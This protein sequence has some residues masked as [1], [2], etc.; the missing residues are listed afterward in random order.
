MEEECIDKPDIQSVL[1]Y[2]C[3]CSGSAGG[4]HFYCLMNWIKHKIVSK[5]NNNTT[6]YQWKK[7]ECEVCKVPLP[8][9]IQYHDGDHELITVTKP[10]SPYIILEKISDNY[11][12]TSLSIIVPQENQSI[13]LGRGH[14]CDLRISDI[15]VSRVHAVLKFIKGKFLIFDNESKFGTLILLNKDYRIKNDKAAIQVGRTVFT[16]VMKYTKTDSATE[17]IAGSQ[18]IRRG[19]EMEIENPGSNKLFQEKADN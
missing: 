19:R 5:I 3:N 10:L 16:F 7:L 9:T 4:V 13:K 6:T 2:P 17:N 1:L 15:S 18:P 12:S 11:Q 8:R 14:Q